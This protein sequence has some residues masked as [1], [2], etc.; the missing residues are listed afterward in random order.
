M[1]KKTPKI[2]PP[3][4]DFVTPPEEDRATAIGNMH[5]KLVKIARVVRGICSR[6]DRQTDRYA[7]RQTYTPTCSLQYFAMHRSRGRSNKIN[8]R[9]PAWLAY[10]SPRRRWR[11]AA[12]GDAQVVAG[13][14]R[15]AVELHASHRWLSSTSA[16]MVG[17]IVA[18]RR[19]PQTRRAA[20]ADAAGTAADGEDGVERTAYIVVTSYLQPS[21]ISSLFATNC[22]SFFS[23]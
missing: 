11:L 19:Q 9:L 22:L 2:V 14:Q 18:S 17:M 15:E 6:T 23:L 20:A 7:D 12:A 3:H 8:R 21:E 4:W 16:S 5:K 1:A 10:N 13:E